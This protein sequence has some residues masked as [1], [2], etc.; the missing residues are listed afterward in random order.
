MSNLLIKI[1]DMMVAIDRIRIGVRQ[2]LELVSTYHSSHGTPAKIQKIYSVIQETLK[3]FNELG[4]EVEGSLRPMS[5]APFIDDRTVELYESINK[6][7][8]WKEFQ[9]RSS[10]SAK[11]FEEMLKTQ[12][13]HVLTSVNTRINFPLTPIS[14]SSPPILGFSNNFSKKQKLDTDLKPMDEEGNISFT[15]NSLSTPLTPASIQ[16]PIMRLSVPMLSILNGPRI[17]TFYDLDKVLDKL[18][19]HNQYVLN[20][21]LHKVTSSVIGLKVLCKGVFVSYISFKPRT[22]LVGSFQFD[23]SESDPMVM[24]KIVMYH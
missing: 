9:E 21:I 3:K 11:M 12:F 19:N 10:Y 24:D 5:S 1:E 20:K 23:N 4:K 22:A 16:T 8:N 14:L 7:C 17:E 13:P 6:E 18:K 2:F 15:P